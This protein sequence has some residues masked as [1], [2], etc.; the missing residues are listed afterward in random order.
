MTG[1]A[2]VGAALAVGLVLG[3]LRRAAMVRAYNH[4]TGGGYSITALF[5]ALGVLAV[6]GLVTTYN[7][8]V[9]NE[10]VA[11]LFGGKR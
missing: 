3:R 8:V 11:D 6:V 1:V 2:I 5:V 10:W 4:G 9:F 7:T